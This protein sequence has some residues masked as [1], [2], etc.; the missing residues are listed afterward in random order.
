MPRWCLRARY[1]R[2]NAA[3]DF[4]AR[5]VT[6]RACSFRLTIPE[7]N[8]RLLVVYPPS[9]WERC[10]EDNERSSEKLYTLLKPGLNGVASYRKFGMRTC[11]RS[12]LLLLL[13][14]TC[15]YLRSVGQTVKSLLPLACK[16]KLDQSE[17]KSLQAIASTRKVMAKR[18][19]KLMQV[20]ICDNLR[21]RL[22]RA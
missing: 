3:G 7:R 21:L 20:F 1:S 2:I 11:V 15:G 13:A 18:S 8:E 22:A 17:R 19:R 6:I 10:T 5:H 9:I 12:P 4:R 14:L 16:F